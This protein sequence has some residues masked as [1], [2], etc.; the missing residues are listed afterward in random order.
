MVGA[1]DKRGKGRKRDSAKKC[2]VGRDRA[3]KTG[4]VEERYLGKAGGERG[5]KGRGR[6]VETRGVEK[7]LTRLQAKYDRK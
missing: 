4:Q 5:L 1:R 6:V 7:D 3:D 2:W